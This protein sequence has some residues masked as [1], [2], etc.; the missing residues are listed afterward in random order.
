MLN[1]FLEKYMVGWVPVVYTCNPSYSGGQGQEDQAS[2]PVWAKK[3]RHY[4]KKYSTQKRAGRVAQVVEC[5]LN[6]HEALNSKTPVP[7]KKK[8]TYMVKYVP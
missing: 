6:K 7:Q 5:F 3:G 2:R 4:L 1:N 8:K